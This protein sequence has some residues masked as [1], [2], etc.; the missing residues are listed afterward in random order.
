MRRTDVDPGTAGHQ[1]ALAAAHTGGDPVET[2][3]AVLVVD[4]PKVASYTITAIRSAPPEDDSR[5]SAL[6]LT[7]VD[8]GTFEADRTYYQAWPPPISRRPR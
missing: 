8:F 1:V 3:I 5:L 7:G 4:Y 2:T 6:A